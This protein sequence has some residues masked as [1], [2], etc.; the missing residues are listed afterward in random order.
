MRFDPETGEVAGELAG[1]GSL[2]VSDDALRARAE[3]GVRTMP[4][5]SRHAVLNGALRSWTIATIDDQGRVVQD[6]VHSEAEA[7]QRVE[8][9]NAAKQQVRK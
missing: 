2:K 3:A 5:G 8:A 7:R 1:A 9:A 6:C 4:D